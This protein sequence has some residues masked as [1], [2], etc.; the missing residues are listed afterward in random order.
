MSGI[1]F[2]IDKFKIIITP[3]STVITRTEILKI[4]SFRPSYQ[5]YLKQ[6]SQRIP[7]LGIL[8]R[9]NKNSSLYEIVR[10]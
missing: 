5:I 1:Q 4:L 3:H 7:D 9:Q 2:P 6:I 10:N 8:L